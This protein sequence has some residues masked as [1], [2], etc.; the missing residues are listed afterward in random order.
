MEGTADAS[1]AG[2]LLTSLIE[3]TATSQEASLGPDGSSH[4]HSGS[5]PHGDPLPPADN[6]PPS[7]SIFP[8][9][10]SEAIDA[11][12]DPLPPAD[13]PPSPGPSANND[14][15]P[16]S[17]STVCAI[18]DGLVVPQKLS[19]SPVQEAGGPSNQKM[20]VEASKATGINAAVRKIL[21]KKT[22]EAGIAS[23]GLMIPLPPA[24][25][26]VAHEAVTSQGD[27]TAIIQSAVGTETR[28]KP[29][30]TRGHMHTLQPGV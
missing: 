26:A 29:F 5:T 16:T 27:D 15:D 14:P 6:P 10:T 1:G 30:V 24:E 28:A 2:G 3:A 7:A 18:D 13:N 17:P 25:R 9:L 20:A 4:V 8:D 21:W 19:P 22:R 23:M 12:G 11:N